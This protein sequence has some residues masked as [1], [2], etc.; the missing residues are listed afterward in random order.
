MSRQ[1]AAAV[2]ESFDR[3]D[4][5]NSREQRPSIRMRRKPVKWLSI[6]GWF[7]VAFV[8]FV[9]LAALAR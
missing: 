1:I 2:V 9:G 3:M 5:T 7:G 6:A 4:P 8:A